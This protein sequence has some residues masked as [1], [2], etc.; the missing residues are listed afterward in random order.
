M[1]RVEIGG[2]TR[3]PRRAQAVSPKNKQPPPEPK[4]PL[5]KTFL[6]G[7]AV[8]ATA[9]GGG[10]GAAAVIDAFQGPKPTPQVCTDYWETIGDLK[11][12]GFAAF[13]L[14]RD[15]ELEERCGDAGDVADGWN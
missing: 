14:L 8:V 7:L 15:A 2:G 12:D 5:W 13:E 11:E 1:A 10:A 3:L 4:T 9:L 6:A